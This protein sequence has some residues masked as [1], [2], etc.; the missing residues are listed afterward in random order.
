MEA[1]P[2]KKRIYVKKKRETPNPMVALEYYEE[3]FEYVTEFDKLK[4][5]E[6]RRKVKTNQMGLK[7][8]IFDI[9]ELRIKN[10]TE[11]LLKLNGQDKCGTLITF[12]DDTWIISP[13]NILEFVETEFPSYLQKLNY[14]APPIK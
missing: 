5:K 3:I 6:V 10:L 14:F 1:E 2:R 12:T 11:S 9:Q 8:F 7:H 4:L 13:K